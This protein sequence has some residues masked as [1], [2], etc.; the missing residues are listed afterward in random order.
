M[1]VRRGTLRVVQRRVCKLQGAAFCGMKN[2]MRCMSSGPSFRDLSTRSSAPLNTTDNDS[3]GMEMARKALI[4]DMSMRQMQNASKVV[5]WFLEN[6]PASY[7]RQ[8]HEDLRG[9]HLTVVSA[10]RELN[11]SGLTIKITKS[12]DDGTHDYS[13]LTSGESG[14]SSSRVNS[15]FLYKQIKEVVEPNGFQLSRVKVFSSM[16]KSVDINVFSFENR[17]FS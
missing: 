9:Q 17:V 6:M 5:P 4:H 1:L 10:M 7:F 16:D 3:L 15:G 14:D 11:Q 13:F 8:V 2:H 12:N